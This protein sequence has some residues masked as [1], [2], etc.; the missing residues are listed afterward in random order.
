MAGGTYVTQ[1][2]ASLG[3]VPPGQGICLHQ[4]AIITSTA[5]PL[6]SFITIKGQGQSGI[7]YYLKVP[8][9]PGSERIFPKAVNLQIEAGQTGIVYLTSDGHDIDIGGAGAAE[10]SA[11]LG[12]N[13]VPEAEAWCR[14]PVDCTPTEGENGTGLIR[15]MASV[16]EL[17]VQCL[18]EF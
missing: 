5:A 3:K 15:C 10:V 16:A 18:F 8:G 12:M 11:T 9:E 4:R 2:P 17:A 1:D 7:P 6:G 13:I 14:V